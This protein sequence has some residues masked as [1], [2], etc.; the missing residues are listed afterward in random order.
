M[1]DFAMRLP[2]LVVSPVGGGII[3]VA[4]VVVDSS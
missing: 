1:A 4:A 2:L 3:V